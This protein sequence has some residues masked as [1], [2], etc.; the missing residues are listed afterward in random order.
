MSALKGYKFPLYALRAVEHKFEQDGF[1]CVQTAQ[2]RWV[3][4]YKLKTDDYFTRRLD[5]MRDPFKPYELY[6]I[7]KRVDNIIQMRNANTRDFVD[8]EGNLLTYVPKVMYRIHTGKILAR[9]YTKR[10]HIAY[11]ISGTSRTFIYPDDKTYYEYIQYVIV[12]KRAL[13]LDIL[14]EPN[15]RRR[16]KL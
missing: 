1:V 9:W 6:P 7:N 11:K 5:L 12:G 8:S 15:D 3:L 4:D 2:N 16:I 10:G 14:T 13:M